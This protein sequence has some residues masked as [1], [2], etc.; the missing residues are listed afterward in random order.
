MRRLFAIGI[1]ILS[2]FVVKAQTISCPSVAPIAISTSGCPNISTSISARSEAVSGTS[3]A[4]G[5]VQHRWYISATGGTDQASSLGVTQLDPVNSRHVST[6]SKV[7]GGSISYW[8][9]AYCVATGVETGRVEV[10]FTA[11]DP[12]ISIQLT[13]SGVTPTN[14]CSEDNVTLTASGAGAS[15]NY[16][17]RLNS[18]TGTVLSTNAS[19]NPPTG[20]ATY[21]LLANNSCG[22][23]KT[24]SVPISIIPRIGPTTVSRT[25]TGNVCRGTATTT[26]TASATNAKTFSW[27]LSNAGSSTLSVG[28]TNSN[29]ATINWDQNFSGIASI[30]ATG[31]GCN[32]SSTPSSPLPITVDN[33]LPVSISITQSKTSVCTGEGIAFWVLSEANVGASPTYKWFVN[34]L[35]RTTDNASMGPRYLIINNWD[36]PES[37]AVTCQVT[38]NQTGCLSGNPATSNALTVLHN[39]KQTLSVNINIKPTRYPMTYCKGEIYFEGTSSSGTTSHSVQSWQWKKNNQPVG[40]NS[41]TYTPTSANPF[42]QGDVVTLEITVSPNPCILNADMKASAST[43]G[44][45]ITIRN[46]VALTDINCNGVTCPTSRC[47]GAGTTDFNSTASNE[48]AGTVV[49]SITNT[50]TT[51]GN[52]IN[53]STGIVTW[54]AAFNG[55]A[56]IKVTANGCNGPAVKTKTITVNQSYGQPTLTLSGP[57]FV[58]SGSPVVF[59]AANVTNFG[60]NPLYRFYVN[61]DERA[62]E[63]PQM[64]NRLILSQW[65]FIN[66]IDVKCTVTNRDACLTGPSTGESNTIKVYTTLNGAVAITPATPGPRCEGTGTTQFTTTPPIGSITN[67]YT[68]NIVGTTS[69]ISQAGLVTWQNG[70]SGEVEINITPNGCPSAVTK[71]KTT[72]TVLPAPSFLGNNNHFACNWEYIVLKPPFLSNENNLINWYDQNNNLLHTGINFPLGFKY[73]TG[74]FTYQSEQISTDGCK[75]TS[76]G[77]HNLTVTDDCD[78]QLNWI[79]TAAFDNQGA[80]VTASK[81]YFDF[82]GAPIQSQAKTFSETGHIFINEPLRNKFDQ[83]VGTG[84]PL[85]LSGNTFRYKVGAIWSTENRPYSYLDFDHPTIEGRATNPLPVDQS[86]TGTL[87]W[88]YG[89]S[90]GLE[91]LT[92]VTSYPYAIQQFYNDGSGQVKKSASAG[93]EHRLGKNHELISGVFPVVSELND[94]VQK[95]RDA[96]IEFNNEV[97]GLEGQ[98]LQTIVRDENGMYAITIADKAGNVV[99]TARGATAGDFDFDLTN[100]VA[101]NNDPLSTDYNPTVY[102]YILDPQ[103]VAITGSTQFTVEDIMSEVKKPVGQTFAAANGLWPA[104]FYKLVP[105]STATVNVSYKTYWKDISYHF[106][107]QAGRVK[108]VLSPNGF[109][110]LKTSGMMDAAGTPIVDMTLNKYNHQGTLIQSYETDAGTSVFKYRRDGK[111]RFSQNALQAANELA[112]QKG[113]FSYT[114]Y[115]QLSRP[116]ESGEY[117][118]TATFASAQSQLEFSNQVIYPIDADG[119]PDDNLSDDNIKDWVRTYYDNA[120]GT[121]PN[122]PHQQQFVRGSISWTENANIQTWYS[123]NEYGQVTWIAQKPRALDRTFVTEYTFD[124]LGNVVQIKNS[125]YSAGTMLQP[126]YHHYEYDADQR[127][128]KVYTSVDGTTKNL[129]ASYEY[130]LR[131]PLKRIELGNNI[132]GID[133]VYNINGWL[134]QINHPD[135]LQD[136]GDDGNDVF[137][138][139]LD[140]Y[141]SN[142]PALFSNIGSFG[143]GVGQ[144][145]SNG[146]SFNEVSENPTTA[147]PFLKEELIRNLSQIKE[148]FGKSNEMSSVD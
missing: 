66:G 76:R 127:L 87:G 7:F 94:Y 4:A 10:T 136:P 122:I 44:A 118:G 1:A 37:Y 123:Y 74:T 36:Y 27:T 39:T 137:G 139:I 12:N 92:P 83:Q 64:P 107:D 147:L 78:D 95:R 124:F 116:I 89:G 11:S 73:Q 140:Y 60:T 17:W 34:G 16:E 59:E 131:G 51:N 14:Y 25:G 50:G 86:A 56:T 5:G 72:Y 42:L 52:Q 62:T 88:F 79:E 104:G 32:G 29:T 106:Y 54:D 102:F 143:R 31:F 135:K 24:S 146:K 61:G 67:S 93:D 28:G 115:D 71:T 77:N 110:Q 114:H 9:S 98:G 57:S 2:T 129:R 145:T 48:D 82:I 49:W 6:L 134:T 53:A 91:E 20:D 13:P 121:I 19:Y 112:G 97:A 46:D 8:V 125:S 81:Q 144:M 63:Q 90:N 133:F 69:Q 130:Y 45:P 26:V 70:T 68:W 40:S 113:K 65:N 58:C 132:Q 85:P 99:V 43:N 96:G 15:P 80:V 138:M 148:K 101:A 75:S 3:F 126:F 108:A 105:L 30:S 142:Q 23:R 84:L 35:E 128:T 38:S 117:I 21:Y 100:S 22:S 120:Y 103:A 41:N 55:E 47:Q 18:S 141:E 111:I 109:I 33:P 119:E